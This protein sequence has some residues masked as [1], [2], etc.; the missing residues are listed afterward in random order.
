MRFITQVIAEDTSMVVRLTL[1]DPA[2]VTDVL[3]KQRR[4]QLDSKFF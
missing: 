2:K 1:R 4:G 3:M